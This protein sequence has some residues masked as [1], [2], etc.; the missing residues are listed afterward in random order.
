MII[1][2]I[3]YAVESSTESSTDNESVRKTDSGNDIDKDDGTIKR[4]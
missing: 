3:V 4:Q 2:K 1:K